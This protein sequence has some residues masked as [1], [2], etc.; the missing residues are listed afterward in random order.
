MFSH[1][2]KLT[3]IWIYKYNK[4]IYDDFTGEFTSMFIW[5][6]FCTTFVLWILKYTCMKVNFKKV[7]WGISKKYTGYKNLLFLKMI[8]LF[9]WMNFMIDECQ[10][11][12]CIRNA[13]MFLFFTDPDIYHASFKISKN[14][15]MNSNCYFCII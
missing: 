3:N 7:K 6:Q 8:H 4:H 11:I 14:R 9:R 1:E 5:V 10:W 15:I 2:R 12:T 13:H